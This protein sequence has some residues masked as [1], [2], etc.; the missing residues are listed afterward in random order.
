MAVD[1]VDAPRDG[2]RFQFR[3]RSLF[4]FVTVA[5]AVCALS[6]YYGGIVLFWLTLGVFVFIIF[7]FFGPAL[8]AEF[9]IF[10]IDSS[11]TLVAA[12]TRMLRERPRR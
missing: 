10:A 11:L 7:L 8:I 4:L 12:T 5:A 1:E 6:H 2:E 3:L 9:L